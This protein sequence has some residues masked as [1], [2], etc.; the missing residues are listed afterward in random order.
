MTMKYFKHV[1]LYLCKH[2]IKQNIS[3]YRNEILK[4]C[5]ILLDTDMSGI[6]KYLPQKVF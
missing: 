2:N 6:Y 5:I 1:S 4:T 3:Y